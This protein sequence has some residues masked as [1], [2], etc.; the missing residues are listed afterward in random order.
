LSCERLK[1]IWRR[2][3]VRAANRIPRSTHLA[4]SVW[5]TLVLGDNP[6]FCTEYE[7]E[8]HRQGAE[9]HEEEEEEQIS[10]GENP[11][12]GAANPAPAMAIRSVS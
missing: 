2:V 3:F 12:G 1:T 10:R 7:P 11:A 4:P 9:G 8:A 5:I 6:V